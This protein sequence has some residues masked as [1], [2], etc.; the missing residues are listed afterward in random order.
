MKNNF[1]VILAEQR[2]TVA[3]VHKITGI[4][5]FTLT[6]IYYERTKNPGLS[7]IKKI[8]DYLGVT[9]TELLGY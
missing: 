2:K 1:R 8:A 5:K 6:N 7:T 4:S 9:I 3:E